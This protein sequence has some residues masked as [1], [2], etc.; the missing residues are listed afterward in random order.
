MFTIAEP[1]KIWVWTPLTESIYPDRK[2]GEPVWE[3]LR[4][5]IYKSWADNGWVEQKEKGRIEMKFWVARDE[6]KELF[7][8]GSKPYRSGKEWFGG[9]KHEYLGTVINSEYF[10]IL[11]WGSEPIEVELKVVEKDV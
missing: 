6:N 2:A 8:Y 11:T 1:G 5:S 9:G 10:K 7:A 3:R 4:C